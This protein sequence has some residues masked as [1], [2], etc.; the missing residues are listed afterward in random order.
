M[1]DLAAK[2]RADAERQR[3]EDAERAPEPSELQTLVA[4]DLGRLLGVEPDALTVLEHGYERPY[5]VVSV[6]VAGVTFHGHYLWGG[7]D[8]RY[9]RTSSP[10]T[11]TRRRRFGRTQS[12]EVSRIGDL[13]GWLEGGET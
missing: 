13:D 7:G 11:V 1:G 2:A 3:A 8:H 10:W 5:Y 9:H 4:Y 6:D 12:R